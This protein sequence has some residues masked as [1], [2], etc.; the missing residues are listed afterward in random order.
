MICARHIWQATTKQILLEEQITIMEHRLTSVSLSSTTNLFDRM[1]D[2][3]DEKLTKSVD[4][5]DRNSSGT[6]GKKIE[7]NR[8]E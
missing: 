1:L 3:I 4:I 8:G 5:I 2:D 6:H 7:K